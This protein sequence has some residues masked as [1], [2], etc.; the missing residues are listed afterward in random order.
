[1]SY[2][3]RKI[4]YSINNADLQEVAI[5]SLG[6]ELT[7]EELKVVGDKLGDRID[8]YGSIDNAIWA[9]IEAPN[10]A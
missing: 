10:E 2:N 9:S 8:W 3:P 5:D 6:R 7:T 1:M 4:V